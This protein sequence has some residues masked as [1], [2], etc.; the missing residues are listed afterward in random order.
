MVLFLFVLVGVAFATVAS[1]SGHSPGEV[2]DELLYVTVACDNPSGPPSS[3]DYRYKYCSAAC[4]SGP[5]DFYYAVGGSC[6]TM[7]DPGSPTGN[8]SVDTGFRYNLAGALSDAQEWNCFNNNLPNASGDYLEATVVCAKTGGW[9]AIGTPTCGNYKIESGEVCDKSNFGDW[10]DCTDFKDATG[11]SLCNGTLNCDASGAD[12]CDGFDVSQCVYCGGFGG[13]CDPPNSVCMDGTCQ[14]N[15]SGNGGSNVVGT[16]PGNCLPGVN[17][18]PLM[19]GDPG[20]CGDGLMGGGEVCDPGLGGGDC[21]SWGTLG[22]VCPDG[23]TVSS[24]YVCAGCACVPNPDPCGGTPG[25]SPGCSS[26]AE[27]GLTMS[28]HPVCVMGCCV[29]GDV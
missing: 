24:Q 26:N 17:C 4:P 28:G 18:A 19:G 9:T 22:V 20:F 7:M 5:T 25:C 3:S 13:T 29:E 8:Y 15:C 12:A 16:T 2:E 6:K 1:F 14:P 10:L 21:S 27:C 23:T 11:N